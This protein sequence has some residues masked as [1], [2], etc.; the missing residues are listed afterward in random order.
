MGQEE[1]RRCQNITAKLSRGRNALRDPTNMNAI[2]VV[3]ALIKRNAQQKVNIDEDVHAL[4]HTR[5]TDENPLEP[6]EESMGEANAGGDDDG[7]MQRV[8]DGL[9]GR[10]W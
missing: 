10:S 5:G 9:I 4:H 1:F 6:V 2:V 7:P 3:L 8:R